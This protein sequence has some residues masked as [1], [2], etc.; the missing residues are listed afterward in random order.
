MAFYHDDPEQGY[1]RPASPYRI[2]GKRPDAPWGPPPTAGEH[3]GRVEQREKAAPPERGKASDLPLAGLKVLDSTAWWAGPGSTMF[4]A[5]MGADVVHVESVKRPDG[6]RTA[7]YLAREQER[8]WEFSSI[9]LRGERRQARHH[10]QHR[11]ASRERTVPAAHP[12]G[13][14]W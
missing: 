14:T 11:R 7:A 5:A 2:N 9:Y 1:T 10:A 4:L 12:A 3:T 8:W 6:M 13:P